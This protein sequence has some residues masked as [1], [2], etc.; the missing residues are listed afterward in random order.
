MTAK[1]KN[2]FNLQRTN[3]GVP[4]TATKYNIKSRLYVISFLLKI[5]V[6]L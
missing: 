6:K 5:S 3:F 1:E 2:L 4:P